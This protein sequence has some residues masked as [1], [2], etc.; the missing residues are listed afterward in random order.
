[1]SCNIQPPAS[2]RSRQYGYLYIP[3]NDLEKVKVHGY[4]SVRYQIEKG[5]VLPADIVEKYKQQFEA[6]RVEYGEEMSCGKN[7]TIEN[8]LCYLDWRE[9]NTER[10][11]SAIYFLYEPLPVSNLKRLGW[12]KK[13]KLFK[14]PLPAHW[15]KVPVGENRLPNAQDYEQ[16]LERS[17]ES[18]WL[19]QVPH[20]MLI[21][22]ED[23][24]KVISFKRSSLLHTSECE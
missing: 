12:D 15:Q 19:D 9:E 23:E 17:D 16:N 22:P 5:L 6:A 24:N 13:R 11:A 2:H 14:V 18:V 4:A 1:M 21:P 10:G 20:F 7:G 3:E 8:I